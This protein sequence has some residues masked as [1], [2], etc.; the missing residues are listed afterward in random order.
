MYRSPRLS[1]LSRLQSAGFSLVELMVVIGIMLVITTL[2]LARYNQFN[3]TVLLRNLAYDIALSI[4]EAQVYG[5]SGKS[6][7]G[8]FAYRYGTYFS[9]SAPTQ[10]I[11][12]GDVNNNTAFDQNETLTAYTMRSGYGL[13][14]MC[15]TRTDG[16][17]RC[18]SRGEISTLTIM[19]KR[20]EPD[21]VIKSD[22][23]AE[24]YRDAT[25]T[26]TSPTGATRSV[27]VVSTGQISVNQAD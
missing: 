18:A 5:I 22:I 23:I 26:L 2:I 8:T 16:A 1:D 12:F 21:A 17:S 14:E 25:F 3:G 9:R 10:Y 6:V 7:S 15:A 13:S 4:R 27:T 19:F 24:A 20:P 11:L